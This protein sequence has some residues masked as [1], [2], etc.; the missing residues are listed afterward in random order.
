[1]G[2]DTADL[3]HIFEPFYRV[4]QA[5]GAEKGGTGLGLAIVKKMIEIHHGRIK[6]ESISGQGSQFRIFIPAAL[7]PAKMITAVSLDIPHQ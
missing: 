2:I 3:L 4:D 5:R 1:M 7:L 6:V